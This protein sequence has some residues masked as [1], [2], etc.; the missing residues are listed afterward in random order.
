MS[1]S[2]LRVKSE[3]IPTVA[4]PAP[5][6]AKP[7]SL[8]AYLIGPADNANACTGGNSDL[9]RLA[10]VTALVSVLLDG[11]LI[12]VLHIL[13]LSARQILDHAGNLDHRSVGK[14]DGGKVH[15]ELRLAPHR[16]PLHAATAV[17]VIFTPEDNGTRVTIH[18]R[19]KRESEDWWNQRA[20]VYERSWDAVL[21][22]LANW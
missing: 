16:A 12:V 9:G 7:P 6:P 20:P 14:D 18:H 17:E 13:V 2:A 1:T 4:R 21:N 5:R 8:T 15:V 10:R 22:A 3:T 19:A 11:S